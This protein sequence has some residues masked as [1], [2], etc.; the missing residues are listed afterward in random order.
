M[1]ELEHLHR[2]R[3]GEAGDSLFAKQSQEVLCFH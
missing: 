1:D 3:R 2:Q